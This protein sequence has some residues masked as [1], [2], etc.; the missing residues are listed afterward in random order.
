MDET[1][2]ALRTLTRP[3]APLVALLAVALAP[4]AGAH[5][6]CDFEVD[7]DLTLDAER[8]VI[9]DCRLGE[10]VIGEA[11]TLAIDGREVDLDAGQRD[12]VEAYASQLR[13]V[14]P[15]VVEIAL[16]GVEIGMTAVSEVFAALLGDEPPAAVRE[17]LAE[18]RAE[19]DAGIGRQD[20]V[21]YVKRDGIHGVDEAMATAEPAI[22]AAV[23]DSVGA[24][25]IALGRSMTEDDAGT[26]EAR[27]TA[28]GERMEGLDAEIEARVA[29]DAEALGARAEGLCAELRAL[30]ARE[31]QLRS[32]V[33]ELARLRVIDRG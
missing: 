13:T 2:T 14:V 12:A 19:V 20:G 10:V 21:W 31:D 16:D 6:Q 17:A 24:L 18:V 4:A 32:R 27:M 1:M 25:L 28:F 30:A 11:G 22:E 9:D 23:A 7:A 33:A 29:R 3:L 8:I 26:F 5:A 15:A